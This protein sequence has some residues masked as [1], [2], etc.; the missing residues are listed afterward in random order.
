MKTVK[1]I[2]CQ[3]VSFENLFLAW[4]NARKGK[5]YR[6]DVMEYS[7]RLEEKLIETQNQL[8]HHTY[9]V[10][11]YRCFYILVPKKRLIMSLQFKDRIVQWAFY[12]VLNPIFDKA[13]IYDS[14]ACRKGK[15]THKAANRL[16][17]W[18][19]QTD[20]KP[21]QYYYLKLDISKFFYRIDHDILVKILKRKIK[22][23]D[24]IMTLERMINCEETKFGLP[25]GG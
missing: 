23:K 8:I 19:R 22:D 18:L 17:Y 11:R 14:Y 9:A 3:I 1:N 5:R 12:Q 16:Q 25:A 15:G 7:D 6:D 4:Q 24:V 2:F 10:G 13:F 21:E 20:R